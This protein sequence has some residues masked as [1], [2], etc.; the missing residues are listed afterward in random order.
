VV[1]FQG[2]IFDMDGLL[3]DSEPHWDWALVAVFRELGA[4]FTER[5]KRET[6]GLRLK[7]AIDLWRTWFPGLALE[8]GPIDAR[9]TALMVER[10][11]LVTPKPGAAEAVRLCREAGCRL[12]VASSSP[13]DIIRAGLERLGVARLFD[14]VVSAVDEE[15]GKPHPAVYLTAARALG[16]EP[17][18]CIAFED[19]LNGL[20]AAVAAGMHCVAVPE[21]HNQGHPGYAIAHRV[22]GS[23]R[24]FT[25]EHLAPGRV[26]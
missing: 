14:A 4:E 15:H 25:R 7:E 21:A 16:V 3:I 2:A 22:L 1:H 23:L 10:M 8:H 6:T 9:L 18:R 12:A 24:E 20:K 17:G 19:S 5:M 13:P 26:P 11:A